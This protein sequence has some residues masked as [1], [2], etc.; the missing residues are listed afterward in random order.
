MTGDD[1]PVF[2]HRAD[3]LAQLEGSQA[4]VVESPTG[5]G[6]T[7]QLPRILYEAGYALRAR[8]GVTQPRRIA[9][10][11]VC[12]FIQQQLRDQLGGHGEEAAYKMRFE[13]TTTPRTRVKV[14]TDGILLQEIKH[15]RMLSEYS[16]MLVDEAHERS[17]NIDF[18]LGLLQGVLALRADFKVIVSSATI[19]AAVFSEYFGGCPIVRIDTPVHPIEMHYE[20]VED[21]TDTEQLVA[22]VEATMVDIE[23]RGD[24]GDVLVFMS[25][26]RE[27][28][29]C[30]TRLDALRDRYAWQLLPL[31]GRLPQTEQ[32]LVFDDFQPLRKIVVATNI[33]ETSITIPGVRY[34]VDSGLAKINSYN[35]RSFTAAL[36]QEGISRASCDQ[37]RGRAGR[38]GP[39]VCYRLYSEASFRDRPAYSLEE[40]HRTDLGE[41]VLR[42]AELGLDDYEEF[43]FLSHPGKER[44]AAAVRSLQQLDALDAARAL[45]ATGEQMCAL[46]ILPR[47]SRMIV[48][49][50]RRYPNVIE[51]T[52]VAAAFLSTL[53]PF[54]VPEGEEPQAR[55]A[56][57]G[58]GH[59]RGDFVAYLALFDAFL[60]CR[61]PEAFCRER[62]LELRT[63]RE[64]VKVK[65]QLQAIVSEMGIPIVGAGAG[66]TGL[67]GEEASRGRIGRGDRGSKGV[68]AMQDDYLCAIGRGSIGFICVE[69]GRNRYRSTTA[70]SIYVHP[71]SAMFGQ[72]AR[73]IVAGEIVRTS[74]MYA[75]TVS[76]LT[77]GLVRRIAPTLVEQLQERGGR[78]KARSG[79]RTGNRERTSAR[80][81][82]PRAATPVGGRRFPVAD[83]GKRQL[84]LVPLA[85]ARALA[86]EHA[87][88]NS[89]DAGASGADTP[90]TAA[91]AQR[92][93]LVLAEGQL[94]AGSRVGRLL[95]VAG[96]LGPHPEVIADWPRRSFELPGD[97]AELLSWLPRVMDVAKRASGGKTGRTLGFLCLNH[98]EGR[99]WFS[100]RKTH[101][102]AAADSQA[103]VEA[104]VEVVRSRGVANA[105]TAQVLEATRQRIAGL[106]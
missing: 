36:T 75:R 98:A 15:D 5:S 19:N 17:L 51:Q 74:R 11:S 84:V 35:T 25:G 72:E 2:R 106:L 31:Y 65:E 64:V 21:D 26:E 39:G 54:V 58:L 3:I 28:R 100:C 68:V 10:V 38:T 73:F 88:A 55:R 24:P 90:Q 30:V 61:D 7:T 49:A 82:P 1:L 46:P 41:V 63:M 92:G 16:V 56:H 18:V 23:D 40:I 76:P 99:F 67:S 8:I 104:L 33:A 60:G 53:S 83:Q 91:M 50:I 32:R 95:A 80:G 79:D 96:H 34:V 47:H 85:A 87:A 77:T 105:A 13:D 102:G 70:G 94:M 9:A 78:E 52:L 57:Q 37:R 101:E 22:A 6:K 44:I 71:G 29:A 93:A 4:I 97:V 66:V 69:S 48:E 27:I 42:M 89:A 45:T 14:M 12:A 20:P 59:A 43:P 62:Y 86:S 81:A 103:S